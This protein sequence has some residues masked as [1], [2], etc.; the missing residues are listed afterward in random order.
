M[1]AALVLNFYLFFPGKLSPLNKYPPPYCF[2]SWCYVDPDNCQ[3]DG[4]STENGGS[5][6]DAVE[7]LVF[8][9]TEH[10]PMGVPKVVTGADAANTADKPKPKKLYYSYQTCG[11]HDAYTAMACLA[12]ESEEKCGAHDSVCA[13]TGEGEEGKKQLDDKKAED[14]DNGSHY[15]SQDDEGS[16]FSTEPAPAAAASTKE[17]ADDDDGFGDFISDDT[18][19]KA[20]AGTVADEAGHSGS[21]VG[22]LVSVGSKV[23]ALTPEQAVQLQAEY[24]SDEAEEEAMEIAAEKIESGKLPG[25]DKIAAMTLLQVGKKSDNMHQPK[26]KP[27]KVSLLRNTKLEKLLKLKRE[28]KDVETSLHNVGRRHVAHGHS[29]KKH[30]HAKKSH[31][32]KHHKHK[33]AV[34]E[35]DDV[36]AAAA[37]AQKKL[38]FSSKSKAA[39]GSGTCQ[40]RKCQ[41]LGRPA[42][43]A[44]DV[45]ADVLEK[46]PHFGATCAAHDSDECYNYGLSGS[47]GGAKT[48][49]LWCCK[50]W[51]Y[52]SPECPSA[53][54]S[55]F[56]EDLYFS[57]YACS[58]FY[59]I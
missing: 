37:V 41:C 53:E 47:Y 20:E 50:R 40:N 28:L 9:G 59:S 24:E 11:S 10:A 35:D 7:S 21:V 29:Y 56:D 26:L 54:R 38:E 2:Q 19:G 1:P 32:A 51:C 6:S 8:D 43:K 46:N 17:A 3:L 55:M 48:L 44:S 39:G 12:F 13:W 15:S 58:E 16:N 57:Y 14:E 52:V 4:F 45:P 30:S 22:G 18:T 34:S 23:K 27:M 36:V 49:G 33:K 42:T 5:A 25:A 31:A